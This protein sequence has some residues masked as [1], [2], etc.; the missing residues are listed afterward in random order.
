[1]GGRR[2]ARGE[3]RGEVVGG[4]EPRLEVR[5]RDKGDERDGVGGRERGGCEEQQRGV[6]RGGKRG[7]RGGQGRARAVP[8][9]ERREAGRGSGCAE[10][11]ERMVG[12][13]PGTAG[14]APRAEESSAPDS[15]RYSTVSVHSGSGGGGGSNE[16]RRARGKEKET[17]PPPPRRRALRA[18]PTRSSISSAVWLGGLVAAGG[19]VANGKPIRRPRLQRTVHPTNERAS[20][21]ELLAHS[22]S[23]CCVCG[24]VSVS[25]SFP[26]VT[27]RFDPIDGSAA[28]GRQPSPLV[29]SSTISRRRISSGHRA[30]S[31]S[32]SEG[33]LPGLELLLPSPLLGR[34]RAETQSEIEPTSSF[35]GK[36]SSSLFRGSLLAANDLVQIF[37]DLMYAPIQCGV[38]CFMCARVR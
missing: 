24:P 22:K 20:P 1:M 25:F 3:E 27:G 6:G 38:A 4:D 29:A 32:R 7:E 26:L 36:K 12:S 9:R 13:A 18:R 2:E 10:A 21:K 17:P 14:R 33:V 34:R 31:T 35:V 28:S 11:P 8:E 19:Q 23:A 37:L 16:R 15:S 5:P 30:H